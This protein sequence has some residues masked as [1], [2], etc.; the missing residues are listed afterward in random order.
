MKKYS[1]KYL[2]N[3][4]IASTGNARDVNDRALLV[5][6]VNFREKNKD[7]HMTP[8]MHAYIEASKPKVAELD[9]LRLLY[10]QLPE[11]QRKRGTK[12]TT[13]PCSTPTPVEQFGTPEQS[14]ES[15]KAPSTKK[16]QAQN[17]KRRI[18]NFLHAGAKLI[19]GDPKID[20]FVVIQ[21]EDSDNK[22]KLTLMANG[23]EPALDTTALSTRSLASTF[24]PSKYPT[25]T[26]P[27]G[28]SSCVLVKP[29]DLIESRNAKR[30]F[31]IH[32]VEISDEIFDPL[33]PRSDT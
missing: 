22:K 27:S 4:G 11:N 19:D 30:K 32:N 13:T 5:A 3:H 8:E 17:Q 26:K 1:E 6:R 21:Q 7:P 14:H 2:E 9:S 25:S 23:L 16:S 18:S 24:N 31:D 29:A 15:D 10:D 12:S 33:Q 28:V 20:I